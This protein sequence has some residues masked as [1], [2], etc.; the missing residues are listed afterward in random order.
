MLDCKNALAE[1]DGDF[2]KAVELLRIKGAKDVGKRAE[3][4]TAEGL[5]AAKDGALI[6]LNSETDFVA[7]NA[8][9]QSVAAEIVAAAAAAK[10][11]DVDAL[12]AA[13]AGDKTVEQLI[14][15]LSAKIG[16][17]LELRRAAYFDGTVETYLHK[18]AADLPPAVGVLVEYESGSGSAGAAAAHAVAL[19]I[20]ALKAKYLTREDVPADL[21]ANE[22]RIAEET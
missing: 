22:R 12:K 20:A 7:K 8:E 4:A 6:E 15:D 19:Q 18:R 5:V 9:F 1:S 11:T 21:V 14:A 13:K 10:A 3:R 2:D 16:E 17:K